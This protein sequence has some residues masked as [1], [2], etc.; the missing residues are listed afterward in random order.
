MRVTF[1]SS[2]RVTYRVSAVSADA[3]VPRVSPVSTHP[4]GTPVDNA[5]VTLLGLVPNATYELTVLVW[6]AADETASR[7]VTLGPVPA[8]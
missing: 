6:N 7:T 2:Q 5:T 4:D 1:T 3:A 8:G